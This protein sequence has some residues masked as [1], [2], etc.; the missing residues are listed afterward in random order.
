MGDSIGWAAE[1]EDDRRRNSP[2]YQAHKRMV[3]EY[4]VL[5]AEALQF[6]VNGLTVGD[7]KFLLGCKT[8]LSAWHDLKITDFNR[9]R[10][11]C[12]KMERRKKIYAK[13]IR[14]LDA[15]H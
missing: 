4:N 11:L 6:E 1:Q 9:L 5:I 12:I 10:D 2:E 8:T 3:D 14:D 13:M 7:L 15:L